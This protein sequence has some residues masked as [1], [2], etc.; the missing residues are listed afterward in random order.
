MD[1]GAK[2]FSPLRLKKRQHR[3]RNAAGRKF[4]RPYEGTGVTCRVE[5]QQVDLNGI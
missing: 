1:V 2:N 5:I 4:F 3:Q